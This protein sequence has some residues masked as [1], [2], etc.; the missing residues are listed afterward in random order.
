M[1]VCMKTAALFDSPPQWGW[2]FTNRD[3]RTGKCTCRPK[4]LRNRL[5]SIIGSN[6][7]KRQQR[8]SDTAKKN[9]AYPQRMR[10]NGLRA[11]TENRPLLFSFKRQL[12]AY[13][14]YGGK[15]I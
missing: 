4:E 10:P 11:Y 2:E 14:S 7:E 6:V 13:G 1:F 8:E 12:N 15:F 3:L 5:G 9:Q